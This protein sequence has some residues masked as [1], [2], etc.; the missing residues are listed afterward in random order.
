[1]PRSGRTFIWFNCLF[2]GHVWKF[3]LD[4]AVAESNGELKG[5]VFVVSKNGA[6]RRLGS[7]AVSA[8]AEDVLTRHLEKRALQAAR[9]RREL[10]RHIDSLTA[11]MEVTRAEEDRLWKIQKRDEGDRQK[12]R[13]WSAAY[14]KLKNLAE[15]IGELKEQ[16]QHL[17]SG[18]WFFEGLP[19]PIATTRT[20]HDGKFTLVIPRQGRYGIVT[21]ASLELGDEKETY[22]WIV[23]VSLRG[24]HSRRLSLSDDNMVGAGSSDSALP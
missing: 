20:D 14:N 12:A 17:T 11:T 1:M 10:Q 21:R 16:R 23:W 18:Q 3:H 5:D 9:K 24:E 13:T 6:K 4:E 8:I 2:C 7:V 22:F 15:R 19:S